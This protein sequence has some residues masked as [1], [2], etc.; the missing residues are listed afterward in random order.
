MQ[1]GFHQHPGIEALQR[2]LQGGFAVGCIAEPE[3][4]DRVAANPALFKVGSCPCAIARPQAVLVIG[5][6]RSR[7]IVQAGA[8]FCPLRRLR[9]GRGQFHAS[10]CRKLLHG[11][12]K[13]KAALVRHPANHVAVR[14]TAEAVV[15]AL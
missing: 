5:L 2:V 11:I 6:C 14:L 1:A 4:A 8:L 9:I 13:T 15:E 12:D 3:G 10:L 7:D